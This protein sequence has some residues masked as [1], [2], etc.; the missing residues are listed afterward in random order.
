MQE[1][2]Y[3]EAYYEVEASRWIAGC[4]ASL[5]FVTHRKNKTGEHVMLLHCRQEDGAVKVVDVWPRDFL[6]KGDIETLESSRVADVWLRFGRKPVLDAKGNPV[7]VK[8]ANGKETWKYS[9]EY[10]QP[11]WVTYISADGEV[12]AVNGGAIPFDRE[13]DDSADDSSANAE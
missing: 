11:K 10:G 6:T 12:I 5:E 9:D 3:N 2:K 8:D 4:G 7:T 13:V 1:V